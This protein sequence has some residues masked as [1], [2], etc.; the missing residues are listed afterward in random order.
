ME[1]KKSNIKSSDIMALRIVTN[2]TDDEISKISES[3]NLE[4]NLDEIAELSNNGNTVSEII[5]SFGV[6]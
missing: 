2:L 3:V 5:S 1:Q 4:D 6:K